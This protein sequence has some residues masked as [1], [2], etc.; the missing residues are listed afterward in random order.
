MAAVPGDIIITVLDIAD[1]DLQH[2]RVVVNW[3]LRSLNITGII[4]RA[5]VNGFLLRTNPQP[6][7]ARMV[8]RRV[9]EE[10]RRVGIL[11]TCYA[12]PQ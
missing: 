7:S 3:V 2:F 11:T 12:I 9:E 4:V 10:L 8:A 5:G 1:T 6:P